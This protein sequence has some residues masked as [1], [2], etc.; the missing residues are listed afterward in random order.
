MKLRE[1]WIGF[2]DQRFAVAKGMP[3]V[4]PTRPPW[5]WRS[6][7]AQI[8]GGRTAVANAPGGRVPPGALTAGTYMRGGGVGRGRDCGVDLGVG[9]ARGVEVGVGVDVAVAVAVAVAVGVGLVGGVGVGVAPPVTGAHIA[10]IIG[11]PVLKKPTVALD[12]CGG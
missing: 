5:P 10:T 4:S 2:S 8:S 9:V 1:P 11:E 7:K 3:D 12:A 6:W